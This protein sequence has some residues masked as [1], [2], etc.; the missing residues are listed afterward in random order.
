MTDAGGTTTYGYNARD[1]LTSK[2]APQGT[3]TY[4][5]DAASNLRSMRSNHTNGITVTY[6][7]DELDRLSTVVDNRLSAGAN[8]TTYVYS[9]T[10]TLK[11]TTLPNGVVTSYGYNSLD[12]L[13]S[14]VTKK[15][16]TTLA[17]YTYTLGS[18][19]NRNQVA[20]LGGR[21]VTYTYDNAYR[22]L[23]ETIS[24]GSP[25][26]TIS[27]GY[28]AVGN[29]PNPQKV[30]IKLTHPVSDIKNIVIYFEYKDLDEIEPGYNTRPYAF[31]YYPEETERHPWY[32]RHPDPDEL[33]CFW[34]TNLEDCVITEEDWGNRDTILGFGSDVGSVRFAE[35][36]LNASRPQ[37]T[38]N[39]YVLEGEAGFRGVGK[40]SAEARLFLPGSLGWNDE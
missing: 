20:E 26:S 23:S 19:G 4:T 37:N 28:D 3:L 10:S 7:Y 29:R 18:A 14:L 5:Y 36:L 40:L 27:Y 25:N 38:V 17:S 24:G 30:H 6:S 32:S 15:N 1:Q 21:T 22:L 16:T 35:L 12:R 11:S 13:T 8:T 39:E 9:P 34:L 2:A 33:P 31:N